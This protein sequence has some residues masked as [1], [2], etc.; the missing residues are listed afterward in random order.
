ML[1]VT[2]HYGNT[3][4]CD[5]C[6]NHEENATKAHEVTRVSFPA[7]PKHP[8]QAIVNDVVAEAKQIDETI[9]VRTDL[10]NAATVAIVELKS[11][12][13]SDESIQNKPYALA[14]A[15][16]TRF[17]HHQ[18]VIFELNR[19]IVE[20]HNEQKAIQQYLNGMAN[21]LRAEER[22]KLKIQ[23]INY[24]PKAPKSPTV[25]KISTS[26]TNRKTKF[27]MTELREA[28]KKMGISEFTLKMEC[29]AN[30]VGVA[31][32]VELL[33]KRIENLKNQSS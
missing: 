1:R 24:T 26:Q 20:A 16:K 23:D 10:F 15:L 12:I 29:V 14:E 28:A 32:G 25:K 6:W 27:S 13:D 22:E 11:S 21:Q 19:Q 9:E 8:I 17:E 3:W 31:E 33:K 2:L 30:G 4:F 5:S 18:A 7:T